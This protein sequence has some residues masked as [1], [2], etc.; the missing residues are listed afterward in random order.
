MNNGVPELPLT[1]RLG[2]SSPPP[3]IFSIAREDPSD[4]AVKDTLNTNVSKGAI[5]ALLGS[6]EN[7]P[8]ET[9]CSIKSAE[10]A[11]CRKR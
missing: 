10:Q 11:I 3:L 4:F 6:T 7:S 8:S 9:S 2:L 1:S 5:D